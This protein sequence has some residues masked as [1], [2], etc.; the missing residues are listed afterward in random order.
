MQ[1]SIRTLV[2]SFALLCGTTAAYA[3][4]VLRGILFSAE[5]LP[6][7]G[8]TIEL[9]EQGTTTTNAKGAFSADAPTGSFDLT[10]RL[11]SGITMPP[12]PLPALPDGV[13]EWIATVSGD[14]TRW[15]STALEA[16]EGPAAQK[17]DVQV[18]ETRKTG[19]LTGV[20]RGPKGP[21]RGARIFLRGLE[22]QG[23]SD[24]TGA[25]TLT[26]PVGDHD[27]TVVAT[28]FGTTSKK[29]VKVTESEVTPL[30]IQ[31]E[32]AGVQLAAIRVFAPYIPGSTGT[33]LKERQESSAVAEVLG[34]EQISK[35]GDSTAASA[36]KRV[37]GVTIVG[38]KYVYVRG[39]GERYSS[40]SFNGLGLPSPEPDRR[41]VPLDL[42]ST[43]MLDS[44]VIQKT[45]SPD[46]PGEFSGGVVQLRSRKAPKEWMGGL[47]VSV[48]MKTGTT[49]EEGLHGPTGPTDWIG[50][51]GG[52][53]EMP[54]LLRE[55]SAAMPIAQGDDYVAGYTKDE[56]TEIGQSLPN[57][58]GISRQTIDPNVGVGAVTGGSWEVGPGDL[59]M[60]FSLD[61]GNEWQNRLEDVT[62]YTVSSENQLEKTNSYD[63]EELTREVTLSGFATVDYALP[64]HRFT[65]NSF[66]ARISDHKARSYSGY[67]R[68]LGGELRIR[69]TTW[70]ERM[71]LSQQLL[72][73]HTIEL[74]SESRVELDW[75]YSLSHAMRL[76]PGRRE[77]R[78]DYEESQNDWFI[79]NRPEGNQI[80][81]GD[82]ADVGHDARVDGSWFFPQWDGEEA[83]L[84]SGLSF[85]T[86]EREVDVR[87][88]KY[89]HK[90]P[91]SFDPEILYQDPED[92]FVDANINS[93]GFQLVEVTLNTD[94]YRA[95][96][97]TQ[98]GYLMSELPL[99]WD[100]EWMGGV[101]LEKSAQRLSTF[102]PFASGKEEKASLETTDWLPAT[103]LTYR[104]LENMNLRM[105]YSR[106]LTRPNFRE[107]SPAVT[108]GL[109]GGRLRFGNPELKRGTIDNFDVRWEWFPRGLDQVA[110][111]GF[112][113][114]FV[115]PIE[116]V[117][118]PSAQL[119]VSYANA[120]GATNKGVEFEFRK[121]MEWIHPFLRSVYVGGNA[122]YIQSTV[123][124]C[125]PLEAGQEGTGRCANSPPA[126]N[127]NR[128]RPLEGQ[129]PY[130]LNGQVGFEEEDWGSRLTLLYNVYGK[131]IIEVGALGSPDSYEEPFHQLDLSAKQELGGGL[132]LGFNAKNL[133]N[134][135]ARE[136]QGSGTRSRWRKGRAFSLKLAMS[137]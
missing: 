129:S 16:K 104:G 23:V 67:N 137:F 102:Q 21:V 36:L 63:L 74:E 62:Y 28:G 72:G 118:I 26:L 64:N 96:Q 73:A 113:K 58:W 34:A 111:S 92:I 35:A 59:G 85:F 54:A 6:I 130:I 97:H 124:L 41:V 56:L 87:R 82:L 12:V 95:N 33:L 81:Y 76:E 3:G 37:T 39:L 71:L 7:A 127:T 51:D 32:S 1:L 47:D 66:L 9:G 77:S 50:W 132:S 103:A 43:H 126:T 119:S 133:L 49:G 88:F 120:L 107:L 5:E 8:A 10:V 94:S 135:V 38:G 24:R 61:Y 2:I 18:E 110:I 115:D 78:V 116:T 91:L 136:T 15:L 53:R 48:G 45:Y 30:D 112:Y 122:S 123:R 98:A 29:G 4:P 89:R 40:T 20:I 109:T 121:D 55:A 27:V 60:L 117:V 69:R 75:G 65:F 128:N 125:P 44:I 99:G 68:D 13:S 83:M 100:T 31:L 134:P 106:T 46:M 42:F 22:T 93:E 70:I 84:K 57:H 90:G 131:R 114:D 79:S 101:R 19:T 25:F 80:L 52:Y 105:G 17:R 108:I 11:P 86:K 14:E